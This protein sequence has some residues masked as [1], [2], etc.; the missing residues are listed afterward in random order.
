LTL[1]HEGVLRS[2]LLTTELG[3]AKMLQRLDGILPRPL[4]AIT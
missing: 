1:T 2:A 3:W 4:R